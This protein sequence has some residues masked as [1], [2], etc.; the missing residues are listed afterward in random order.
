MAGPSDPVMHAALRAVMAA[1][2]QAPPGPVGIAVSG[3]SDSL[4]LLHLARRAVDH[5]AAAGAEGAA[6]RVL[7]GV[8]VDHGLRAASAA[9]A[10]QVA[11]HC[12]GLGLAHHV[13]RWQG[14]DGQ[15]NLQAAARDARYRLMGDWAR[16]QGIGLILL[17]HTRDDQAETFVM[18]LSR[19]AGLDGLSGMAARVER[20]GVAWARPLLTVPRA[21]L[22]GMLTQAGVAWIEDPSND[23]LR[24]DRVRARQVLA[25]LAPLGIGSEGLAQVMAQLAEARA[26]LEGQVQAVARG[27]IR[28]DHGDLILEAAKWDRL[29]PEMRRRCLVAALVWVA[30]LPYPP[31]RAE[32]AGLLAALEG[33]GQRTLAGCLIRRDGPV[34]RITREA[35]ALRGL[36]APTGALWDGRWRLEGPHDPALHLA[37]LGAAGLRLCPQWRG[38]GLP[39]ATL[40]ASPA[41]WKGAA[42]VAAPLAGFNPDWSARIVADFHDRL[43][44]H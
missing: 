33:A 14:W 41:V 34:I 15:G 32:V 24:F 19:Q 6:G 18:R 4:A 7:V 20:A 28:Q 21:A 5:A 12:A 8:T 17:G 40:C 16:E 29:H 36:R 31:R 22:R 11:A 10:A 26:A 43:L 25:A 37:A 42:L 35:R 39:R 13:L 27:V 1:L 9:E 30:G 44:S 3:G 38:A 2:E 23:D